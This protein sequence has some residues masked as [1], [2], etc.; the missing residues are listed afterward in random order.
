MKPEWAHWALSRKLIALLVPLVVASSCSA[1][2]QRFDPRDPRAPLR[3]IRIIDLPD[4]NGRIDHMALNSDAKHLFIAENGN[5]TV[6][7]VDLTTG[8]LVSRIS[9]LHEPQ[10]VAWL[11]A[12]H[13]IA[14]TSED[15]LV[16]F[17]RALDRQKVAVINLG[18]DADNVR[19]D[20]RNGELVVGYGAGGLAVLDAVAH[21]V[22]RRLALPA[23]P[24]SFEFVAG[25]LFVN[26]PGAHKIVVVDLNLARILATLSTGRMFGNFPM[27]TNAAASQVAIAYRT[28]STV[29]VLDTHSGTAIFSRGTCGDA[30][31]LYF[32]SRQLVVVCGSGEVELI[33]MSDEHPA[34]DVTTERGART[35]IMDPTTKHLF[36]AVPARQ[37]S[38]AIWELSFSD[39]LASVV[40]SCATRIYAVTAVLRKLTTLVH[41]CQ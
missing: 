31:D 9:G 16:T 13:E 23:H 30:D 37:H 29:S 17:Y 32:R 19:V 6:D 34:I 27:A 20:R 28:P 41:S 38:A 21:K 24:E 4:V 1:G 39:E 10:G 2:A 11:P 33:G 26:L 25:K 12:Q 40:P 5:G 35:G 7:D 36:V 8:K 15:G 18:A 22:I 14:V 3:L